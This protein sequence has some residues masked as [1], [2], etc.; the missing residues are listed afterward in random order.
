MDLDFILSNLN[1]P[2]EVQ[3]KK[4]YATFTV[5]EIGGPDE[6]IAWRKVQAVKEE[7]YRMT[8]RARDQRIAEFEASSGQ[9]L[10]TP[11][12][13]TTSWAEKQA[14]VKAEIAEIEA[15]RAKY[16]APDPYQLPDEPKK[17]VGARIAG[18]FKRIWASANF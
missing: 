1:Q 9:K 12:I 14:F 6:I 17:S 8:L 10:E 11:T 2:G 5:K 3:K 7:A 16:V 18:F 4:K 15:Q 13:H